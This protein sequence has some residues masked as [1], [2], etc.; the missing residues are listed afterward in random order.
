MKI[1]LYQ[2]GHKTREIETSFIPRKG[3]LFIF[4]EYDEG[5]AEAVVEDVVCY[6]NADDK[7]EKVE[8]FVKYQTK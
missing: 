1:N 5:D 2:E 4:E 6:V 8:V 7:V 3:D